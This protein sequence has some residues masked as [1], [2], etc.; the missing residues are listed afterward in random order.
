VGLYVAILPVGGGD[1]DA[2][3][4]EPDADPV[5]E[6]VVPVD[7]TEGV[8]LPAP[9]PLPDPLT[10]AVVDASPDR[11]PVCDELRVPIDP[12]ESPDAVAAK[13][14]DTLPVVVLEELTHVLPERE[15][16]GLPDQVRRLPVLEGDGDPLTVRQVPVTV[17]VRD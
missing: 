1:A 5:D 11:L 14:A 7:D 10:D 17:S 9:L 12:V 8:A 3:L 6:A 15:E 16:L 4:A 2:T 13:L